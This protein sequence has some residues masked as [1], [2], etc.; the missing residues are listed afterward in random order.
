MRERIALQ[1]KLLQNRGNSVR[2]IHLLFLLAAGSVIFVFVP[3]DCLSPGMGYFLAEKYLAVPCLLFFGS[4]MTQQL[5]ASAKRNLLLSAI[6][7]LWFAAAQLQHHLAQMGTGSFGVFA[8]VY[9]LAF[10]FAATAEQGARKIGIEWIGK[11]Y[12]AASL[13]LVLCGVMLLLDSVPEVLSSCF[14]LDGGRLTIMWH[15]NVLAC[16][17]MIGIGFS[18]YFLFQTENKRT[19]ATLAI[20]SVILFC[21]MAL[22]SSRT[23]ILLTC[24]LLGGTV[25]FLIWKGKWKSFFSGAAAAIVVIVALFLLSRSLFDMHTQVQINK[26]MQQITVQQTTSQQSTE[27]PES[28]VRNEHQSSNNQINDSVDLVIDESTGKIQLETESKQHSFWEDLWTLNS[29]TLIWGAAFQAVRDNPNIR[30]WGTEYVS[31]EIS[32]RNIATVGHAHNSWIQI[33]M[34]LGTPGLLVAL[35]YTAIALFRCVPL[36]WRQN[37]ELHK[38]VAALMVLCIMAAG[39]LEP[40]LFICDI[41]TL[42]VNFMFFFLTGYLD[43]WCRELP[44][45]QRNAI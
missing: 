31:L 12:I 33:L 44:G 43:C 37:V 41:T 27:Q 3:I 18:L 10:P 20:L 28:E 24:A 26:L 45:K 22:T 5:S 13:L 38:K 1:M 25:F 17:F 14:Y 2:N 36:L 8:V 32:Y 11:I 7:V 9:L 30:R 42:F 23:T 15:P 35:A 39:F 4:A 29:R 40:Y 6:A 19:K 34:Y 21:T 16:I